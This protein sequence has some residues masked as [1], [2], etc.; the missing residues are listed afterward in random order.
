MLAREESLVLQHLG[1]HTTCR[2]AEVL[3]VCLPGT[4]PAWGQR[5]LGN[6]EWL[7][8]VTVYAAADGEPLAVQLTEKGTA[9]LRRQGGGRKAGGNAARTAARPFGTTG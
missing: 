9:Y 5:V 6:L 4:P 3:Q 2:F 7:G 8:Y 1:S